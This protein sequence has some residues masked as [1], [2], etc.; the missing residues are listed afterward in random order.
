MLQT[1]NAIIRRTSLCL[2]NSPPGA[3]SD[4]EGC[5][6]NAS[7]YSL[8][9]TVHR[10]LESI[11][12]NADPLKPRPRVHPQLGR[13]IE[14]AIDDAVPIEPW[15]KAETRRILST[16][17]THLNCRTVNVKQSNHF[18]NCP[19]RHFWRFHV[20]KGYVTLKQL[21]TEHSCVRW[22]GDLGLYLVKFQPDYQCSWPSI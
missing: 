7:Y 10:S 17:L 9:D 19:K 18:Y 15:P 16:T 6:E 22:Q 13:K 3:S 20:N 2:A 1:F 21:N 12:C 8:P 11:I 4:G 5:R 14:S